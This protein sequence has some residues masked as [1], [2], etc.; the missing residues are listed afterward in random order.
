MY[1]KIDRNVREFHARKCSRQKNMDDVFKRHMASGDPVVSGK[2]EA[3]PREHHS[4]TD[5]M[6]LFIV[7]A[8]RFFFQA[9]VKYSKI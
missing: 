1:N 6:E 7:A 2:M 9:S 8:G 4:L 3:T 5:E